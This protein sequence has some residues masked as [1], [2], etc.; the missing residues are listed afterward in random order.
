MYE[1]VEKL[2]G[3][4][5]C[6]AKRFPEHQTPVQNSQL[7]NKHSQNGTSLV[8]DLVALNTKDTIQKVENL[9]V[10]SFHISTSLCRFNLFR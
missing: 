9:N 6:E 10:S 8:N 4:L 1:Q 2:N 3:H 5:N 7:R